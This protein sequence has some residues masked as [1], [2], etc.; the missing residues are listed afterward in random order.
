[1]KNKIVPISIVVSV[2][3][4]LTLVFSCASDKD[5]YVP[6][7]VS[8]VVVNLA[9]VPYANLSQYQFF[10]G[11][12]LLQ[13]DGRNTVA[14]YAFKTD[15]LLEHNLLGQVDVQQSMEDELKAIIQ[16][17]MIRMNNDELV[18]K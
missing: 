11:D 12:Y 16:Q 9:E 18:V 8:P 13:F 1:M 2:A 17:Y 5:E 10:K 14:M 4:L 3:M 15:K 7:E 6:I